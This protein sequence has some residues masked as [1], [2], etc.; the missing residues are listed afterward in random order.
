[1]AKERQND[2][3]GGGIAQNKISKVVFYSDYTTA[4]KR[5]SAI[6]LYEELVQLLVFRQPLSTKEIRSELYSPKDNLLRA[7]KS[8]V[9]LDLVRKISFETHTLYVLNGEYNSLIKTTLGL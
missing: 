8:L 6:R 5:V 7:L 1:M 9:Q 2:Q 4:K 3:I